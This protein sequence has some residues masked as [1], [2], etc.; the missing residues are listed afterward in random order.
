VARITSQE[1]SRFNKRNSTWRKGNLFTLRSVCDAITGEEIIRVSAPR[2]REGYHSI[3]AP[4]PLG[5]SAEGTEISHGI[6]DRAVL[7]VACA[8]SKT[9]L[10]SDRLL[11]K[12][13]TQTF[14]NLILPFTAYSGFCKVISK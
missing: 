6:S 12:L 13:Y 14:I 7:S 1:E 8:N 3:S 2:S 10:S 11:S 9:A 4:R 5:D